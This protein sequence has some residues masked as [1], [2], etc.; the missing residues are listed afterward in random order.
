MI[1]QVMQ[2]A[3]LALTPE[4][5]NI[6][7][8]KAE[9]LWEGMRAAKEDA[10]TSLIGR[11]SFPTLEDARNAEQRVASTNVAVMIP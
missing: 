1:T 4:G 8:A 9:A 6:M 5:S 11:R 7:N 10:A 2:H 3:R